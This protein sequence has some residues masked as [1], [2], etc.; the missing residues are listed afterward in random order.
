MKKAFDMNN[1]RIARA[2]IVLLAS[3]TI[4]AGTVAEFMHKLALQD[5]PH[6]KLSDFK[7][8]ALPEFGGKEAIIYRS[9]DGARVAAASRSPAQ[10]AASI[11]S[12][13]F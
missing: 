4:G 11:R 10:P 6:G 8:V 5:V 12:M 7:W 13:S 3:L 2:W 1:R 9:P